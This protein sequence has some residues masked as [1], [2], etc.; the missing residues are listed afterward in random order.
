MGTTKPVVTL[1][2]P[3]VDD[4][5]VTKVESDV[6]RIT[7]YTYQDKLLE[8][9]HSS[10]YD[11]VR[12]SQEFLNYQSVEEA[13]YYQVYVCK[14]TWDESRV[15]KFFEISSSSLKNDEGKIEINGLEANTVYYIRFKVRVSLFDRDYF[16]NFS[17]AYVAATKPQQVPPA[18]SRPEIPRN[19][20]IAPEDGALSQ[21][22]VKLRW[23]T[24]QNQS[25]VILQTFRLLEDNSLSLDDT[26]RYFTNTLKQKVEIYSQTSSGGFVVDRVVYD[27]Y[28]QNAS[29]GAKIYINVK[30]PCTFT[31]LAP[32]TLYYFSIKA[33]E[34]DMESYWGSIAV[35]TSPI[36]KPE[37]LIVVSRDS[38]GHGISIQWQANPSYGYQIF[39]KTDTD[40]VFSMVYSGNI[41]PF[42]IIDSKTAIFRF[43]IG[44][45][46]SNTLY[47]I[48]VRS[49]HIPT[50]KVSL[51]A[52]TL[53]R[54]LFNQSDFED[55]QRKLKEQE[56]NRIK[57]IQNQKQVTV[58][59]E[60]SP[61]KYYLYVIDQNAQDEIQRVSAGEFV[62]DFTKAAYSSAK[63]QAQF[64]YKVADLLENA[65]KNL[66]LKYKN[67][68]IKIPAGALNVPEVESLSKRYNIDKTG[69]LLFAEMKIINASPPPGYE[70]NS[71]IV[72][73]K[74][75]A[76]Y[77]Y[78]DDVV[79]SNFVK[80]VSITMFYNQSG[81]DQNQ[82][83]VVYSFSDNVFIN[84]FDT[85]KLANRIVFNTNKTGAYGILK[86]SVSSAYTNSRYRDDIVY[87][88]QKYELTGLYT[89]FSQILTQEYAAQLL[90][91]VFSV[92]PET[93]KNGNLTR[94][95]A[96]YLLARVY[97]AKKSTSV[98]NIL[99]TKTTSFNPDG[100]YKKY[101]LAM[102][103]IG[104]LD[105]DLNPV[106]YIPV[107]E[108]V[109]YI[110]AAEKILNN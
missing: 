57:E 28:S 75:T 91:K 12:N 43:Y 19:F 68:I 66:V 54:T 61:D 27:V 85:D 48:R 10:V 7:I 63:A 58:V 14:S 86:T 89:N 30:P 95:E 73:F 92:Q 105:A 60:N 18:I 40:T 101:I 34:N 103:S 69:I 102:L 83:R 41:S 21:T 6:S 77:Y 5:F 99:I 25:Y 55:E 59:L 110:A 74:L 87:L 52:E 50:G 35:T 33:I 3:P 84:N 29:V 37:N 24:K 47:H 97:E 79:I 106:E 51:F 15:I 108:F 31:N 22:S 39:V 62:I 36:E 96:I 94:Q 9:V 88:A 8:D 78:N 2:V 72:S 109:H 44:N 26:I 100:R 81:I 16:S 56:E 32:N 23:D 98:D 76:R 11:F 65:K 46:K 53:A 82:T 38:S 80:P 67:T 49:I 71:E 64:S 45:L 42:S 17:K 4:N 13:V 93:I 70:L 104:I 90:K 20:M 1:I 107:D